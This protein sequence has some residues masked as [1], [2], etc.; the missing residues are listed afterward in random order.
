MTVDRQAELAA[1]LEAVRQEIARACS[2]A[3]RDPAEVTLIAVTKTFPAEDVAR[4]AALGVTDIGENRDQEA[5]AKV[6][7]CRDLPVRW[8]FVG[9]LQTNKAKSVAGYA[10]VVH[11]VDRPSLVQALSRAATARGRTLRCLLQV[12]LDPRGAGTAPGRGGADPADV[13]GLA[14]R[15]AGAPGLELGGVMAVAPL[16]EDAESAFRRLAEVAARVRDAYPEAGWISA[17]MSAD[18]APAIAFGATHVRI[19][20]RLLGA[21]PSRR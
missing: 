19:G 18:L 15:V 9:Q 5:K 13:L 12:D 10:E 14:A 16:G 1:N 11:S 8:H 7:A 21:R 2:D 20:R 3:G 6:E 17:G 4:L